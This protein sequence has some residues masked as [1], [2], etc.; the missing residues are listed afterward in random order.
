MHAELYF[1]HARDRSEQNCYR[2]AHEF[3][4]TCDTHTLIHAQATVQDRETQRV[5]TPGCGFL[6][7]R[8]DFNGLL[9]RQGQRVACALIHWLDGLNVDVGD[10]ELVVGKFKPANRSL[11]IFESR[12]HERLRSHAFFTDLLTARV[13]DSDDGHF[14]GA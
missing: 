12:V 14:V 8:G 5:H 11:V 2:T 13:D 3:S 1:G 9:H 4:S 10:D 7:L 6:A